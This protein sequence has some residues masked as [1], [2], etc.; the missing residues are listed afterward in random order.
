LSTQI[1]LIGLHSR[2]VRNCQFK[3]PP[4]DYPFWRRVTVEI[5]N[6]WWFIYWWIN[7]F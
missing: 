4:S 7:A 1:T 2:F 6:W 3:F 5:S